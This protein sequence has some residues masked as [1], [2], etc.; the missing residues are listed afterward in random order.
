[1]TAAREYARSSKGRGNRSRST[2]DQHAD[3]LR[4]EQEFGPWAWGE[5]YVDTGSA[6]TY[7]I[8]NREA[9]DRLTADLATREFGG[10]GTV[11]VLWEISRLSREM[12]VGT[13]IV[14]LCEAG[15][16][17]IHITS[18]E[19]T[20]NPVNYNDRHTLLA[21][22]N[23]AEREARRLSKRTKRGVDS[24]VN[25][26]NDEGE[27]AAR[28]HGVLPYG[29]RRRYDLVDGKSR[30]VEQYPDSEEAEI[31]REAYRRVLAGDSIRSVAL[32]FQTRGIT[33]R[34]GRPVSAATLRVMLTKDAYRGYRSHKGR[35]I[36]ASWP[37]LV[38]AETW[39]GVQRLL[40]D[41]SRRTHTGTAVRHVL[42]MTMRCD[43]CEGPMTVAYRSGGRPSAYFCHDK[44]CVSIPKDDVDAFLIGDAQFPGVIL[45]YLSRPDVAAGLSS[46]DDGTEA[47]AVRMELAT[48]RAAMDSF[49][50]EDPETP[51]EARIIAR[52]ISRLEVEI[53]ELEE[54]ERTLTAPNPLVSMFE[55]GPGALEHWEATPINRRRAIAALLLTPEILGQ[56]RIMRVADSE[57]EAVQDRIRWE[58]TRTVKKPKPQAE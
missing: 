8:R 40:A 56:V 24:N 28:P 46:P 13:K 39:H 37:A 31:I 18:E 4:A 32:D 3:N 43:A 44:G 33:G 10:R 42:T 35:V 1:M 15:E 53:S 48:A 29:Y 7:A 50:A 41:S 54:R 25:A 14:D 16:Y 12:G 51:A 19:R 34:R 21:G 52:K 26:K 23:D 2:E 9:F 55:P 38:D 5:A 49:E 47:S 57:S 20:Y 36:R 22:I 27:D 17:L 6:S 58:K 45:A 30:S 11:L